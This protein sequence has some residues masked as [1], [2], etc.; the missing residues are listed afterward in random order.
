MTTTRSVPRSLARGLGLLTD[1]ERPW[2]R[3]FA[4]LRAADRF[5][6][7]LSA[8]AQRRLESRLI[9]YPEAIVPYLEYRERRD[10]R[11]AALG[12]AERLAGADGATAGVLVEVAK[13]HYLHDA[14]AIG[15]A[16]LERAKEAD[17]SY[18]RIYDEEAWNQRARGNLHR[19]IH[20][21]E[22]SLEL[23]TDDESRLRWGFWLGEALIR[24]E[25]YAEAWEQLRRY[26]ALPEGDDRLLSAAYCAGR[27]GRPADAAAAYRRY[28]PAGEGGF[29]RLAAARGQFRRFGRA[30]ECAALLEPLGEA[31]ATEA[32]ELR[33][34]AQARLGRPDVVLAALRTAAERPDRD[35]RTR[36]RLAMLLELTEDPRAALEVYRAMDPGERSPL[37]RFRLGALLAEESGPE[38]AV[39]AYLADAAPEPLLPPDALAEEVDPALAGLVEQFNRGLVSALRRE[40]LEQIVRRASGEALAAQAGELLA[41]QLAEAGE[42]AEAWAALRRGQRER[43]PWFPLTA[44]GLGDAERALGTW[45]AE[46]TETEPIQARTVLYESSLGGTTSCNPLAVCRELLA[47]PEHADLLH[48]WSVTPGASIHP[49]LR[50]RPNVVFVRKGSPGHFRYLASAGFIVNNSTAEYEFTKRDGQRYLNTW[51]GVPWKTMGRDNRSEPF[52]YGNISRN[53]L[54]ADVVLGPDPHTLDVLSRAHDVDQL[55][56]QAFVRAGYPRNDLAVRLGED[57]RAALRAALGVPADG[58]LVLFMPTWKGTFGAR[59]A[60]VREVL[61]IAR[62]LGAPGL[63]V[64]VRAHHYVGEAFRG[65]E[66]PE[67]WVLVPPEL[68]T[69]ELIGAADAVVTDFSS[70]L[71]DAAAVGVPVVKLTAGL[72]AYAAHRGLYFSADEVPGANARS[73][74]EARWLLVQ[75]I[76][77]RQGFVDEYAERTARFCAPEDGRSAARAVALLFGEEAPAPALPPAAT[78]SILLS[79]GGLPPN[80]ITRSARSLIAA[81]QG[82]GFTPYVIPDRNTLDGAEAETVDDLRA[83]AK[84]LP[85]VGAPAGTRMESE[86]LAYGTSR[87]YVDVPLA[88]RHLVAASRREARRLFGGAVFDA[89]VEF[90]AYNSRNIALV[91]YGVRT[92]AGRRGVVFHNEM[93]KELVNRFPMLRAG[94]RSLDRMDFLASVSDGV[95]EYNAETLH[96]HFGVPREK[97]ITIE[98]TIDVAEIRRLADAPLE[99]A[100]ADW[101]ASEGAHACVVAR[102]SPEKNHLALFEALAACRDELSRPVRITCLGD[103]PLRR[104]AERRVAELGLGDLVRIRGLVPHPQAHLRAAGRMILPSLHEGQPLVILEALTVGASVVATDTPGSRSALQ[105][106]AF[107]A[108]VPLSREGL[109]EALHRVADGRLAG[110]RAFDPEA[111]AERSLRMFLD[112]VDPGRGGGGA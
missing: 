70:V 111:F 25:R 105:D 26:A 96:E 49:S 15:D 84:V 7:Q 3:T 106:G 29:D 95:R 91:G 75:A 62:G 61:D 78:R 94:F 110:S 92:G 79:T 83:H 69:N 76:Q 60:E 63:T 39:R 100:D 38:E 59:D 11:D 99:A 33:A 66:E 67:G 41:A 103:G 12:L 10:G 108:L 6:P 27:I 40:H 85:G 8:T 58:R 47:R 112:A 107:G 20:A 55:A 68:D 65:G 46:W 77:D 64:A 5:A 80:G 22:R 87:G 30:D 28:A 54:H 74:E 42:W 48:V 98:N 86:A 16:L 36:E 51:H 21:V 81:L 109:V 90:S 34:L 57:E 37:A 53:F 82:T 72:E 93:W 17:A 102:F 24:Q 73:T 14:L 101:Y 97:H 71:F 2:R 4:A 32:L 50:D 1:R 31:P 19:E 18:A 23:A 52:A 44:G 9:R 13:F 89:A 88:K 104:E 35:P 56:P 43:L 45:Y